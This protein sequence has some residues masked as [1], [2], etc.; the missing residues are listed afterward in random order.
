MLRRS[1]RLL[2]GWVLYRLDR[3]VGWSPLTQLAALLV[4]TTGLVA[5]WAW[6]GLITG[7]L[8]ADAF[9]WSLSRFFDGGTMASD[10]GVSR[11]IIALGVT[12]SGVLV[13]SLTIGAIAS[14]LGERIADLQLGTSPVLERGHLLVLG[15]DAKVPLIAR[16][17][18]YS[19][20]RLKLVT[21]ALDEKRRQEVALREVAAIPG[22]RLQLLI[23]SGDPRSEAAL[24]RVGADRAQVV[25]V[26][27]SAELDDEAALRFTTSTLLALRRVLGP[28]HRPRIVVECRRARHAELIGLLGEPGLAGPEPLSIERVAADDVVARI[29]AQSV[30]HGAIHL[31]LRELLSFS[32]SELYL[33]PT[34]RG[35]IGRSFAEAHAAIEGGILIGLHRSPGGTTL[36]PEDQRLLTSDDRLVVLEAERGHFRLGGMLPPPPPIDRLDVFDHAVPQTVA[37]LGFNRTVGRLVEEL[38]RVLPPGSTIKLG[39]PTLPAAEEQWITAA[40][41]RCH[42]V[43]VERHVE[44]P[45]QLGRP[46]DPALVDADG[47]ILLGCEDERDPDGDA[48]AIGL[49]LRLRD[50][51]RGGASTTLKRLVTEVRDPVLGAQVA[52]TLDDFLVSTDVVA[53]V[54]A[55]AAFDPE[56]LGA[57]RELL[58]MEGCGLFVRSRRYYVPD[59]EATFAQVASAARRRGD[60]AIGY[61]P[62]RLEEPTRPPRETWELGSVGPREPWVV[63]DPPRQVRLPD[64]DGVQLIVLSRRSAGQ[65]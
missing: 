9:W 29:L 48:S 39:S 51:R 28:G 35:L 5:F 25:L 3:F 36:L 58:D 46:D 37:V 61:C 30:R 52:S 20:R 42:K 2:K 60:L 50:R 10:Q 18:A 6:L 26:V 8:E 22:S 64:G 14:K 12:A 56:I 62:A 7:A 41:T 38:E 45:D 55:Q 53:M 47:A 23:R 16:E 4:L 21:L 13:V 49:L 1:W 40:S 19:H 34:P 31:A 65:G 54:L 43:R 59:G 63:L 24:L 44:A 15:F 11:R 32:G 27:P 17:L 33:E 57:Y